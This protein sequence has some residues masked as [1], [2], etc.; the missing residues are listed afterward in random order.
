[1]EPD[2]GAPF[3]DRAGVPDIDGFAVGLKVG[4]LLVS[5]EA[6]AGAGVRADARRLS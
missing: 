6:H 3:E 2:L 1:M 5:I 4:R